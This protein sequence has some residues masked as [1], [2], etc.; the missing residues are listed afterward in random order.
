MNAIYL[1]SL[2]GT[3]IFGITGALAAIEHRM[4]LFGVLAIAFIVGNGGGTIRSMILNVS[5]FWLQD[6]NFIFA[7]IIPASVLFFL[8][9]IKR[10]STK[11]KKFSREMIKVINHALL[12]TDALGLGFFS[13]V[14]TQIALSNGTS[15]LAA[16]IIG[17][18]SATGGGVIRD[19]LCNQVPLILRHEVYAT[20]ALLGGALYIWLTN[21]LSHTLNIVVVIVVVIVAVATVRLLA[22]FK[23]WKMPIIYKEPNLNDQ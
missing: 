13:I 1:V 11:R 17:M 7:S 10:E 5:P 22:V 18:I 6:P 14:G 19:I 15:H 8:L 3:A 23:V 16:I 12:I 21:H 20:P 2:S 9:F 4:D